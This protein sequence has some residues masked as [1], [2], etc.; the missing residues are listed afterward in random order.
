MRLKNQLDHREPFFG[1]ESK[2]VFCGRIFLK[3]SVDSEEA[4]SDFYL[5]KRDNG[6][7]IM[8]GPS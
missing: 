5:V 3:N 2:R 6:I 8:A 1:V 7:H 4:P